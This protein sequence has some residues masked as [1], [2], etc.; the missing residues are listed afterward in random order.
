MAEN[1]K[2]P[3]LIELEFTVAIG[4]DGDEQWNPNRKSGGGLICSLHRFL[5]AVMAMMKW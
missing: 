3:P 2:E 1:H 5:S 4:K